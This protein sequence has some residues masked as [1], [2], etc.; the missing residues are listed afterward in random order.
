M[1]YLSISDCSSYVDAIR[2]TIMAGGCTASRA[3]FIG[4]CIGA[5]QGVAGIPQD[6]RQQCKQHDEVLGLSRMVSA[7]LTGLSS[8]F[9][10]MRGILQFVHPPS[11]SNMRRRPTSKKPFPA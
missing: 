9:T 4:A 1:H 2:A 7:R 6:W 11:C 8:L 3:A 5:E 10:H